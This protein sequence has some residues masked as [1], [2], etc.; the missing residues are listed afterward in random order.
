MDTRITQLV[1]GSIVLLGVL[2][3]I[4]VGA[5][6]FIVVPDSGVEL[7]GVLLLIPLGL[8]AIRFSGAIAGEILPRYNVAKVSVDGPISRDPASPF[9]PRPSG[10]PADQ[11]VEQ[12]HRADEDDAVRALVVELNTPG[13]QVLPSDDIRS[14][15]VDFDGPTIAYATDRCASGGYWI[16]SGCDEIWSRKASIIGSIGVI[17]SLVNAKDLAEKLGLQ[18]ERFAA[19]KYKDAGFPLKEVSD[20]ER[21]YLQGLIDEYYDQFVDKIADGRELEPD[22]IRATEARVFL[23]PEAKS[24]G[25]VDTIGDADAVEDRLEELLEESVSVKEFEP[26]VGFP[27]R[28]LLAAYGVAYAFG[29]GVGN[30]VFGDDTIRV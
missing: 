14:A 19:G 10:I 27:Q 26:A 30:V 21:D 5:F 3:A 1:R 4:S 18:Y 9:P 8:V 28:I 29:S 7:A 24:R 17:G 11:I 13:G 6:L 25:L 16:A 12:I 2:I 23:G 20:D 22:A 15:A